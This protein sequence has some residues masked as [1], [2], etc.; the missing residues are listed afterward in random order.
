MDVVRS[1]FEEQGHEDVVRK[2][3]GDL[4]DLADAGTISDEDLD[5]FRFVDTAQ[6]AVD[7]IENWEPAPPRDEIPGR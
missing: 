3:A 6:E 5:L 7:I 4:G 1:D 2:V